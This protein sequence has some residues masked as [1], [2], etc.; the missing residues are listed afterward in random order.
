M[1]SGDITYD[2]KKG[3]FVAGTLALDINGPWALGDYRDAGIDFGVAPLPTING[4]TAS[5]FSGIKAWYVNR[6]SEYPMAARLFARFAS[7]KEAQLLDYELTGAL[8]SNKEAAEDPAVQ[9]NDIVKGFLEQFQQSTPMPSIPEMGNVW[10]PIAAA[11]SD[12]WNTGKD[13]KE[14]LDNAVKQIRDANNGAG[15]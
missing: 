6:Y 4:Q 5:S 8:P 11:F 1:N 12:V 7:T 3:F 10:S 15:K 9:N 2:I 13:A 14:A